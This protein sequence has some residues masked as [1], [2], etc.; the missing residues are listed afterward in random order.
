MANILVIGEDCT[1]VFEYGTCTRLNPEAPTPVFVSDRMV[2]NSGMAGNVYTNLTRICPISWKIE[3]LPQPAGDIV[4]HRFV[5]TASNYIILRVD[6]DGPV[7][8]FRLTPDVITRIHEADI[9]V[10]SDYNK[11]FLTEEDLLDIACIAKV[12][13]IDTKKPLGKWAEEFDYI[14]INKKEFANPAHDKKFIKDN[15][16]KII[17]TK[18]EEGAVLGKV[19]VMQTRKVEVKDVSGAGDTF[20]AGLVANYAKTWDIIEAIKFANQC[21]GEA[22]SH[23]GVVSVDLSI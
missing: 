7:D 8:P 6:K 17:V 23:K 12:S 5:D 1:D 3:F 4:K 13:F 16:D 18:G 14:K 22:V 20:L 2:Q 9:V 21:A 19:T 15:L 10:I 11:G